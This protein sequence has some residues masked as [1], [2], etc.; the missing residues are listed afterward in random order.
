MNKNEKQSPVSDEQEHNVNQ[1]GD[2]RVET[3][4][5]QNAIAKI[6][7]VLAALVLWFYVASANTQIVERV[8]TGLPVTIRNREVL[9]IKDYGKVIRGNDSTV[10][11]TLKGSKADIDKLS[12]EDIELYVDVGDVSASGEQSLKILASLPSGIRIV[13]QSTYWLDVYIDKTGTKKV[14]IKIEYDEDFKNDGEYRVNPDNIRINGKT[15]SEMPKLEISGPLAELDKV[16]YAHVYVDL[17]ITSKRTWTKTVSPVLIEKNDD[18]SETTVES[19]Y[20]TFS[21]VD[22]EVPVYMVKQVPLKASFKHGYLVEG[23]N[24]DVS[25]SPEKIEIKGDPSYLENINE[26]PL[27]AIDEKLLGKNN[28]TVLPEVAL[29][30]LD[31]VEILTKINT[32]RVTV[33]HKDSLVYDVYLSV[34]EYEP[35]G[36]NGYIFEPQGDVAIKIRIPD[37]LLKETG[38]EANELITNDKVHIKVDYGSGAFPTESGNF[39][40]IINITDSELAHSVY[41]VYEGDGYTHYISI[42]KENH[43][44][45]IVS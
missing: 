35:R 11:V 22:L 16:D 30:Q 5:F 25:I 10:D 45:D 42:T 31:N 19:N 27:E 44:A 41:E 3:S 33:E 4:K 26:I 38:V 15:K 14:D 34:D 7:C 29:E 21:S 40:L 1:N 18:T 24:A 2:Y 43:E 9:A 36:S 23:E 6:L 12:V 8:F 39:P 32:A 20:I 28:I 17:G 37:V 13:E